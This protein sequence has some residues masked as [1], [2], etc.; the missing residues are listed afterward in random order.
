M[1]RRPDERWWEARARTPGVLHGLVASRAGA[2]VRSARLRAVPFSARAV[3]RRR[4]HRLD[5]RHEVH[6]G[7]RIR[8]ALALGLVLDGRL[9]PDRDVLVSSWPTDGRLL[10]LPNRSAAARRVPSPLALP[11]RRSTMSTSGRSETAGCFFAALRLKAARVRGRRRAR[12]RRIRSC[13]AG[14]VQECRRAPLSSPLSRGLLRRVG[15][16]S[17]DG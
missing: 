4:Q 1:H 8:L 15:W 13:P 9:R 7:R 11:P 2:Q 14:G 5:N 10:E 12:V 17:V 6:A 3:H 16:P